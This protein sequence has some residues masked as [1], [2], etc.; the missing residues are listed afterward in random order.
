MNWQK[1]GN[2]GV[3]FSQASGEKASEKTE[4]GR[5]DHYG[6][7]GPAEWLKAPF[8]LSRDDEFSS[9]MVRG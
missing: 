6:D 1:T 3:C 4:S 7:A 9:K 8:T 2:H 5:P